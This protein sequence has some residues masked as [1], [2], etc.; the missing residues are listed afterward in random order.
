MS[1]HEE[2]INQALT[3]LR[4]PEFLA[5]FQ[6]LNQLRDADLLRL[7]TS[8]NVDTEM[9][10]S[11]PRSGE[12]SEVL[13]KIRILR[14]LRAIGRKIIGDGKGSKLEETYTNEN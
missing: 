9:I 14:D 5:A 7:Y 12:H 10:R 13:H 1:N 6:S 2:N 11:A 3:A 8:S 4:S